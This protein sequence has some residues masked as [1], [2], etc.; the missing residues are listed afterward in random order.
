MRV[1]GFSRGFQ[2]GDR[3]PQTPHSKV[4]FFYLS[5]YLPIIHRAFFKALLVYLS[6]FLT[7]LLAVGCSALAGKSWTH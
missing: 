6:T 2:F 5:N 7:F 1:S 4:V 3:E